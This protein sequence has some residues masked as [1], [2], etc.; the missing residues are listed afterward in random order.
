MAAAL[1]PVEPERLRPDGRGGVLILCD[2]A[3]NR[4]PEELGDLGVAPEHL[5]D[6]IAVDIGAAATARALSQR[7]DAPTV[8]ARVSR[9]VVDLNRN[10]ETQDPI[11]VESDGL[12]IPGN[13]GLT[14]AARQ[15]RLNAYFHPYHA[16][17]QGQVAAMLA[18]GERPIVIGLH[19][20]TP[21]MD[22]AYRPWP[23]GFLYDEDPR[24]FEA[25]AAPLGERW[26]LTVGDNQ[27]YSGREL[28][29]TMKRHGEARGLIQ[30]TIEIRQ[31][32]LARPADPERWADILADCLAPLLQDRDRSA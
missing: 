17:C 22:G 19:S 23:I 21:V 8:L 30:A 7:L 20:F 14:P 31:D 27:P 26:G 1:T 6:H 13:R 16:A 12:A 5:D 2:H 24:L 10:P 9:L 29:Y 32:E 3:S 28:Y 15:A 18:R 25:L 4:I 11:P